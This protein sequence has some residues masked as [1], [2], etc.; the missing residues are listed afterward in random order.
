M[1]KDIRPTCL[2]YMGV[3]A[4]CLQSFLNFLTFKADFLI[5]NL[6]VTNYR[7]ISVSKKGKLYVGAPKGIKAGTKCIKEVYNT[8]FFYTRINMLQLSLKPILNL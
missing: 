6:S 1:G 4:A 8:R 3:L 2:L 5:K 7:G